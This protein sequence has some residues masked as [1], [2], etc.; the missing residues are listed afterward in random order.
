VGGGRRVRRR[1]GDAA[2]PKSGRETAGALATAAEW[3]ER[4]VRHVVEVSVG[5]AFTTLLRL[6][7]R[8]R[9]HAKAET[10]GEKTTLQ[11]EA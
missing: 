6:R 8:E 1:E 3:F 9:R 5:G 4:G 2:V 7:R 11:A 10:G